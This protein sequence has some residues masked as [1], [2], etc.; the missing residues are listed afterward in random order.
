MAQ[1]ETIREDVHRFGKNGYIEV[2]RKRLVEGE[3]QAE[4]LLLTRG[5]FDQEGQK[6]WTRF[7]TIPTDDTTRAWLTEALQRA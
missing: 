4:F 2:A 5:Y 3:E 7:V 6:R 1:Y